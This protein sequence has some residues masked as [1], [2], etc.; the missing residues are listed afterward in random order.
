MCGAIG[1]SWK[2]ESQR[3]EAHA[4]NRGSGKLL[5]SFN[6]QLG[7]MHPEKNTLINWTN[8]VDSSRYLSLGLFASVSFLLAGSSWVGW[9]LS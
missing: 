3:L 9:V 1:N 4:T 6:C 5:L 7:L 2:A 8:W